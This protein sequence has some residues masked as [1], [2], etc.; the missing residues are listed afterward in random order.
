[1][2]SGHLER[3]AELCCR[4][5]SIGRGL[6]ESLRHRPRYVGGNRRPDLLDGRR[7]NREML[8]HETLDRGTNERRLAGQHFVHHAAQGVDIG[9]TV[10]CFPTSLLRAHIGRRAHGKSGLRDRPR[11][12]RRDRPGYPE[13]GYH[14]LSGGEQDVLGFDIT[15]DDVVGVRVAQRRSDLSCDMEGILHRELTL[16][17]KTILQ[18]LPVHVWHDEIEQPTGLSRIVER[19]HMGML[20]LRNDLDLAEKPVRPKRRRQFRPEHLDR[21]L[22]VV[23]QV[24]RKEHHCHAATADLT[25]DGVAIRE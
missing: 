5:E 17:H 9:T 20:E 12:R 22:A 18:C 7:L 1:M 13:I 23:L 8:A 15:V 11:R 25:F 14:R 6:G 2:R 10:H 16:P 24:T 4:R 19:Q 3:L 21:D